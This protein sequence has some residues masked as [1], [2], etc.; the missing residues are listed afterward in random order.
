MEI[1]DAPCESFLK[2]LL[3]NDARQP[4]SGPIRGTATYITSTFEYVQPE[5]IVDGTIL[6]AGIPSVYSGDRV[7]SL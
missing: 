7:A 6:V 5:S 1:A 2:N 4:R 3:P